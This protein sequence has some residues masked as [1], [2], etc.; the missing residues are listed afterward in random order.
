MMRRGAGSVVS[1]FTLFAAQLAFGQLGGPFPNG[2]PGQYPGGQYPG[3]QYPGGQY[4]GGGGGIPLPFPRHGK[5]SKESTSAPL[6]TAEGILEKIDQKS[7][8]LR[9]D[10][11][12]VLTYKL[13]DKT[14]F[15]RESKPMKA[16]E[17]R[18]GDKLQVDASEDSDGYLYAVNVQFEKAA[19]K[20]PTL[21]RASNG[22]DGGKESAEPD[23]SRPAPDVNLPVPRDP[24][25]EPPHLRRGVPPKHR[26]SAAEAADLAKNTAP[27]DA[28]PSASPAP[29]AAPPT[30]IPP[31]ASEAEP[32]AAATIPVPQ[33][34]PTDSPIDRARQVAF[35]FTE[36]LPNYVCQQFT[37]R[38]MSNSRPVEWQ[39]Q[40]VVSAEVVYDHGKEDYRNVA[41]NGHATKKPMSELPGS[42]STGE[43]GTI[44][45]DILSPA[46]HADFRFQHEDSIAHRSAYL[47]DY[48]VEQRN[49]H[50]QVTVASQT[51]L[52][53]YKGSIWV[54]KKTARVLRIEMSAHNIPGEFPLDTVESVV[55]YDFVRLGESEFLLPVHA[56]NLSCERGSLECSRNTLDFRNCHKFTGETTITFGK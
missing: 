54:D 43:F 45:E 44:L 47:F 3:G 16:T 8:V 9:A 35:S 41:I 13:T 30:S 24:N 37:T 53:A 27:A 12:R 23:A 4:P 18:P 15:V 19:E 50:W 20:P 22:K 36:T 56:E 25:E 32:A 38:Y 17:L 42:W 49:S 52:P 11:T 55:E 6:S 29:A 48:T 31:A 34:I 28:A 2:G 51:V 1:A 40:D 14:K 46:T 10:D 26:E 21:A 5:S 7:L 33:G 39:A